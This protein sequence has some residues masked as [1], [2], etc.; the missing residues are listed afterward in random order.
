M[1]FVDA[2]K[3]LPQHVEA[4]G[5]RGRELVIDQ[6]EHAIDSIDNVCFGDLIH[7][8]KRSLF[9]LYDK[10][11][12]HRKNRYFEVGVG[13]FRYRSHTSPCARIAVA[14]FTKPPIL[15]PFK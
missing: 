2:D 6:L 10:F 3:G 7:L 5:N 1:A 8:F 14:T 15:A 4:P 9:E 13:E 11:L 12:V